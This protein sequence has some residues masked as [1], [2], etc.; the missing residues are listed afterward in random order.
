MVKNLLLTIIISAV[1]S[2][3]TKHFNIINKGIAG[4]NSS[5]LVKRMDADVLALH[6]DLVILMVGSND[7]LNSGKFIA[8]DQFLENY[9][10]MITTF[11]SRGIELVV[12][13]P[14]PVDT[15][16]LF[17]RHKRASF[18]EDPNAKIDSAGA[19]I[20]QLAAAHHLHFIDIN[21]LIRRH[22]SP[23]RTVNSLIVN[24]ANMANEDG[25]HPTKE[26]YQLIAKD[27][28]TYLKSR[29]LL[30]KNRTIVCFGDSITYGAFMDGEGS[31]EGDTY[32][33]FL[34]RF[35]LKK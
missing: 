13:K 16:Y 6:P 14:P 12:M 5:D 20:K 3:C 17:K 18:S 25:V 29:G 21:E 32:P 30:R 9:R 2:S 24:A 22:G 11:K 1:F 26:G 19:L 23:N 34:K 7:M 35:I 15:G 10:L 4:N 28:Y 27:I 31:V 33:A 8:Y